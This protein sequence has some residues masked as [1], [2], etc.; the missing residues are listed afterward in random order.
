MR[1]LFYNLLLF[2]ISIIIALFLGEIIVRI[3]QPQNLSGSWRIQTESGL[4]VNKSYGKARDQFNNRVVY[5]NFYYPHL[6][7]SQLKKNTKQI[8][9]LGDSF[10]FGS[11]LDKKDTYVYKLQEYA[12]SEF[13]TDT[14]NFLNASAQGWGTADY[15][16]YVEEFGDYINPDIILVF[17]NTDDIGRSIKGE[18]YALININNYELKRNYTSVSTFKKIT[19][20]LPGYNWLLEHSHLAQLLRLSLLL[21][22]PV[23]KDVF[24]HDKNINTIDNS[25]FFTGPS[26]PEL[27]LEKEKAIIFG[28]AL[29]LRLKKWC[30]ERKVNLFITTTNWHKPLNQRLS[31]EPTV[32]F[33]SIA[34]S[35]FTEIE[36]P[37]SDKS[38]EVYNL[39][40][41]DPEKYIIKNE[42]HPNEEGS[43]LIANYTWLFLKE[44]LRTIYRTK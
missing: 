9:T 6:R 43:L 17:I 42:G 10:T 37:Y 22:S 28:K 31:S 8:L 25:P 30:D 27:E 23:E 15:V 26:S 13:G 5:Y 2:S 4:L 18:K 29:F 36:V 19:N 24:T 20:S 33:M 35:F 16:A 40:K 14:F 11:Y 38:S 7:D 44:N 32:A 12:D 1:K 39:R 21:L 41:T 34:D 3:I